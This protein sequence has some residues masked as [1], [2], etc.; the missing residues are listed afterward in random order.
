MEV[1]TPA[2]AAPNHG[3]SVIHVVL[4]ILMLAT[5]GG[6]GYVAWMTQIQSDVMAERTTGT[7][8]EL[9]QV[10]EELAESQRMLAEE[11]AKAD[12]MT[13]AAPT[14]HVLLAD[15]RYGFRIVTTPA[16][17]DLYA[18]RQLEA[19]SLQSEQARF[20]VFVPNATDWPKDSPFMQLAI[21]SPA[22]HQRMQEGNELY[23]GRELFMTKERQ[24]LVDYGAQ[25][26]PSDRDLSV[27]GTL[28]GPPVVQ[29]L[30]Y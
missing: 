20:G 13:E 2:P 11:K 3:V 14:E 19:R 16:C 29:Q 22:D 1:Q 26:A 17:K 15:E 25:D 5:L 30:P 28:C 12:A 6:V 7:E 23:P 9:V 24:F 21:I 27:G 4:I 8:A 10:R 18:A